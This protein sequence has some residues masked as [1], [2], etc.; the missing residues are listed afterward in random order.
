MT[1]NWSEY[2]PYV[3]PHHGP[4]H[5]MDRKRASECFAHLMASKSERAEMLG[6]LLASNGVDLGVDDEALQLLNDWF[7][8]NVRGS[9]DSQ[10][11]LESMW[12]AVVNDISLHLG[13]V[14]VARCPG[15]RWEMFIKG[16]RDASHQR[17]VIVGFSRVANP[18]YNFDVDLIV[19]G[20]AL[21]AAVGANVASDRFV[22]LVRT[23][24][25]QA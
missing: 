10:D 16:R 19:A 3:P 22:A 13:D 23:V 17:H 2:R 11:R 24:Q 7:R 25:S 8:Q 14:M 9:H 20:Y 12:Y 6:A 15:L 5:E 21:R 18:D 1:V 4:L